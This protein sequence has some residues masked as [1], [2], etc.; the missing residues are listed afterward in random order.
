MVHSYVSRHLRRQVRADAQGR[1]GYC[2]CPQ[3]LLPE[4]LF[5]EHIR[6]RAQ[7]GKTV[8]ENLWLSCWNC[9]TRKGSRTQAHDPVTR[10]VVP[11][12]NPRTQPWSRHFRWARG[13]LEIRGR[14]MTGRATAVALDLNNELVVAVRALWIAAGGFPPAT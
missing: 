13:G 2:L 8:R 10:R 3:S 12:F 7:G 9:N 4:H 1:C 5:L 6:P 14:T 11:L